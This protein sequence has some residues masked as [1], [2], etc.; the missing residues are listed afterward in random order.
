M[1]A[2]LTSLVIFLTALCLTNIAY[3]QSSDEQD[4]QSQSQQSDE[5]SDSQPP[6]SSGFE[7]QTIE[8]RNS[9]TSVRQSVPEDVRNEISSRAIANSRPAVVSEYERYVSSLAGEELRRFGS[10]LIVP[11]G[12]D[13][14]TP[15]NT[16]VPLDYRINSGDTIIL[17]LTGSI[18][19]NDVKLLVDSEGMVFVPNIGSIRVGGVRYGDLRSVIARQ[20]ARFYRGFDISVSMGELRG[21]TIYVTGFARSPGAYTI[22]SLSTLVNAV[23]AAGGPSAGGSFR[24]IQLRRNG[25]TISDFDLYDLLLKGDKSGD[26]LL[27]NG[28]VIY[29]SPVGDQIA[30]TGSVNNSAIFEY[31]PG[32]TIQDILFYAGG[33]STVADDTRLFIYN[34]L[35]NNTGGWQEVPPQ[36][37]ASRPAGRSEILRVLS[38]VG[39]V[40]PVRTQPVLVT[41]NGEV[42]RPGQYY[43]QPGASIGDLVREAGGLTD[44]A[45]LYASV[46][47]RQSVKVQQQESY[48]RALQDMRILLTSYPLVND[49]QRNIS[50]GDQ[51]ALIE[52]LVAQLEARTPDGRVVFNIEPGS[53]TLPYE[54]ALQ[55]NDSLLIPVK[56]AIIGI[57][58]AVT[59]PATVEYKSGRTVGDY[60]KLAGGVQELGDKSGIFV[61]RANG[62]IESGTGGLFGKSVLKEPAYPGDLIFVPVDANRGEFWAK[63]RDIS[64]ILFSATLSAAVIDGLSSN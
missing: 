11:D 17:G 25:A 10:N 1:L 12:R 27:Q 34:P 49:R 39:Y 20:V 54:L 9:P 2:K 55:D 44:E 37:V 5:R 24:S 52:S 35:Q 28:D 15:P 32:E 21:L 3:A 58:G 29:V 16:T 31:A 19:A 42:A 56:P 22:S 64:Q 48:D 14:T 36:E 33:V 4:E 23:L 46:F 50:R 57:F 51:L 41:I 43:L 47:S 62:S 61:V 38:G 59:S 63:I 7:P 13:F 6:A 53:G 45:Y 8:G 26:M 18:K 60:L 30:I 40:R